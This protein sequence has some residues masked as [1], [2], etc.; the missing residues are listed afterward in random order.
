MYQTLALNSITYY[1]KPQPELSVAQAIVKLLEG[2]GVTHAF[3]VSGVVM[4]T[5][6]TRFTDEE[7]PFSWWLG[8]GAGAFL[9][10]SQPEGQGILGSK[11]INTAET[12]GTF[13]TELTIDA[14]KKPRLLIRASKGAGRQLGDTTVSYVRECCQGATAD[15]NV[16]L[17]QIDFFI[18]N[19]PTAWYTEV[20]T[21]AL[22]IDPTRTINV[23]PLYANIGPVLPLANLYHAAASGKIRENDRVLV[24]TI[25]SVSN[26]G[27]VVMRWGDVALG[28]APA[29]GLP[30]PTL[31][32]IG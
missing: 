10:S 18:F 23:N 7:D 5:A 27:A 11:F 13:F 1:Q 32:S 4:S 28:A 14:Q 8:D 24:Y 9:V 6:Y 31:V 30:A 3:G 15:A 20:C 19:T 21:H 2:L 17:A 29:P 25:G 26:A 16:T 22:A 12:C